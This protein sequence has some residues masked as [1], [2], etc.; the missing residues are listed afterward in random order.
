MAGIDWA[1]IPDLLQ[2]TL[3]TIL[4]IVLSLTGTLLFSFIL[5]FLAANS[6]PPLAWLAATTKAVITIIRAIPSL[7]LAFIYWFY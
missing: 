2:Q 6:T 3:V 4:L 7:I 1:I 5:S